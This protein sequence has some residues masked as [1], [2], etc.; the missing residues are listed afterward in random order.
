MQFVTKNNKT[1]E[2]LT[3]C[4]VALSSAS[5]SFMAPIDKDGIPSANKI[6]S[7]QH[8]SHTLKPKL[9]SDP[10]AYGEQYKE[11]KGTYSVDYPGLWETK[12]V[13]L[14]IAMQLT[15]QK[16][17]LNSK[18]AKLIILV[19]ATILLPENQKMLTNIKEKL[20]NMFK[21][22]EKNIVI[23]ITKSRMVETQL[24]DEEDVIKVANGEEG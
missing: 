11:L 23:G 24:G 1:D 16:V 9:V 2:K 15:L 8:N 12:G 3:K 19:S 5:K 18:S 13:E 7:H 20:N 14:D 4:E 17:L 10:P 22:P 6:I 21:E